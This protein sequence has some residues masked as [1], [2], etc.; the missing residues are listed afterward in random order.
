MPAQG[1]GTQRL[2]TGGRRRL[3]RRPKQLDSEPMLFQLSRGTAG[4]VLTGRRTGAAP[5]T[6]TGGGSPGGITDEEAR[7][8]DPAGSSREPDPE[9]RR[10]AR[11]IA[12]RLSIR[13]PRRSAAARQRGS[14][15]VTSTPYRGGSDD[16]DLDATIEVLAGRP[17]PEDRDVVVRERAR[18][19]RSVVLAIDV[20]G[21]MRGQ[22]VRNAA[23]AVG[24][25][26][27]GLGDDHV[28]VV[29][30]WSDAVVLHPLGAPLRPQELLDEM[31]EL[32]ARGLTNVAFPLQVAG[33]LLAAA[34]MR[35]RRV[36]LLTDAVH[37]AGPD[38]R[39]VASELPRL[40][41]LIDRTGEHD[42]VL[43]R[44][45]A[46]AGHGLM[47]PVGN[48]HDVAPAFDRIFAT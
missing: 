13:R 36:L 44:E 14:G 46:D 10:M 11:E 32:P 47:E 4:V 3:T 40:D 2:R 27:G 33:R 43:G 21:S 25:L 42:L 24:A 9:V 38:P 31:L 30:F 28:A 23:A 15:M 1:R 7:T 45:L 16:I 12:R 8:A 29:A 26:A 17:V 20:S 19:R 22:R 18:A 41:V 5:G 35:E 34:P 39:T 48:H 6:A 37:N